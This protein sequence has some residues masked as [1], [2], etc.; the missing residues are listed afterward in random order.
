M[1]EVVRYMSTVELG[2]YIPV[3]YESKQTLKT[4]Y[5]TDVPSP[6]VSLV[7]DITRVGDPFT[8][9]ILE[10]TEFNDTP[11]SGFPL[12]ILVTEKSGLPPP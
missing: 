7:T 1:T 6:S 4:S 10:A 9:T 5:E 12:V 3:P 8:P 2:R 11:T